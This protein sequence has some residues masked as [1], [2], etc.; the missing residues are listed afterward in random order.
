MADLHDYSS[1]PI[2]LALEAIELAAGT[3]LVLYGQ[4]ALNGYWRSR[5][6]PPVDERITELDWIALVAAGS[7][8][9]LTLVGAVTA[10]PQ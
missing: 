7:Y 3:A 6:G 10:A 9:L 5:P 8:A 2:F 4:H 1:D